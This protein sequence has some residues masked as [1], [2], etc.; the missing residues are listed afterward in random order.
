MRCMT[1]ATNIYRIFFSHGVYRWYVINKIFK[2]AILTDIGAYV[3]LVAYAILETVF[4][5][6]GSAINQK[7]IDG[8]PP[9]FLRY[10][11]NLQPRSISIGHRHGLGT[12]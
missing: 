1:R 9:K 12:L 2:K 10:R 7:A 3:W 11:S 5:V 6:R 8:Y 4:G